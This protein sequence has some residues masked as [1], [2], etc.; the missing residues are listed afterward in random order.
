MTDLT[1]WIE[2][3]VAGVTATPPPA[4]SLPVKVGVVQWPET[5]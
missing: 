2:F 1:V 4:A 3:T 5:D